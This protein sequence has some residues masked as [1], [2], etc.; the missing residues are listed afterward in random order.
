AV[1]NHDGGSSRTPAPR[2][3]V[4]GHHHEHRFHVPS[5]RGASAPPAVPTSDH[6]VSRGALR[7]VEKRSRDLTSRRSRDLVDPAASEIPDYLET[8][9][10]MTADGR[11][12]EALLRHAA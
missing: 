6:R 9:L 4:H 3:P 7:C 1:E 11:G 12:H 5:P 10:P 2:L 8:H